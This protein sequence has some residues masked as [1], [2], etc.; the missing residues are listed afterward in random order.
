MGPPGSGKGTQAKRLAERYRVMHLSTGDMLR[1]EIASR[2]ALGRSAQGYMDRGDLVPDGLILDM[3]RSRLQ[4]IP[5]DGGFI[6]DGFPRTVAQAEELDGLLNGLHLPL[7]R[8]VL[9][10]VSDAQIKIRLSGRARLE[11][12]SDDT[13]EVIDRRLDVY[14]RQTEPLIAL[15]EKRGLLSRVKGEAPVESVFAELE[16]LRT[17]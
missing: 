9:I 17:E 4:E 15:Y 12:R 1:A 14:R 6:L 16:H 5:E 10:E 8:A 7:E 3:I 2:H 13:D 11:G